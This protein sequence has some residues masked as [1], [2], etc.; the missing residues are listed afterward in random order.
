MT[1][2]SRAPIVLTL[3][4]VVTLARREAA[5]GDRSTPSTP[6]RRGGRRGYPMSARDADVGRVAAARR[7]ARSLSRDGETMRRRRGS[8]MPGMGPSGDQPGAITGRRRRRLSVF[9][10]LVAGLPAL[11]SAMA[12]PFAPAAT[13]PW[14][15]VSWPVAAVSAYGVWRAD[16]P[17]ESA[18]YVVGW[19]GRV[20]GAVGG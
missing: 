5:E 19:V 7:S 11:F 13:L 15:L 18:R 4:G 9:L 2:R 20:L 12:V 16:H 1:S 3:A 14:V 6:D 8:T 10:F 17:N